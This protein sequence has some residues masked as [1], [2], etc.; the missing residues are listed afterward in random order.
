[1]TLSSSPTTTEDSDPWYLVSYY[2]VDRIGCIGRTWY[3]IPVVVESRTSTAYTAPYKPR[4]EIR[5]GVGRVRRICPLSRKAYKRGRTYWSGLLLR[6]LPYKTYYP[7]SVS[8][9][10]ILLSGKCEPKQRNTRGDNEN[11]KTLWHDGCQ[12][13]QQLILCLGH[14]RTKGPQYVYSYRHVTRLHT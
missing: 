9:K 10:E 6:R 2:T 11:C 4:H 8:C 12:F 13:D 14:S 7:R 5:T 1:M 3:I